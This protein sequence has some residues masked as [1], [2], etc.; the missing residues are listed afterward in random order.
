[1]RV[2]VALLAAATAV[3]GQSGPALAAPSPAPAHQARAEHAVSVADGDVLAVGAPGERG[4]DV[5]LPA[6][7]DM[8]G[9]A[10][11]GRFT[12]A[13]IDTSGWTGESC[14]T[15]SGRFAAVTFAPREFAN[16]PA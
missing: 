11:A 2:R 7:A 9:W 3:A 4:Y 6:P 8:G 1:M 13:G 14:T 12:V 10:V 16:R 5:L 15:G